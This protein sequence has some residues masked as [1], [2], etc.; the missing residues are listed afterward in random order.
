MTAAVSSLG[1]LGLG[2][3][4]LDAWAEFGTSVLG[5][6]RADGPADELRLRMDQR[7]QRFF[8]Y[9]SGEDDVVFLGLE[10][11][12]AA[13]LDAVCLRLEGIGVESKDAS[14][15]QREARGVLDMVRCEDPDGLNV[16][17][18]Y[19]QHS[20]KAFNSPRGLGGFV[21]GAQGLGHIVLS[22]SDREK[23]VEF[24][25]NGLGFLLSDIIT[26]P[27]GGKKPIDLTFLHCNPRHHTLALAPIRAPKRLNH[28]MLQVRD[29][30][31]VGS[32]LDVVQDAGVPLALGLGR[33]TND[34]MTSFYMRSP[35]GFDV[36]FGWGAREIDDS[37]WQVGYYSSGSLWGH[38]PPVKAG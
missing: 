29:F 8:L 10:V 22:V 15:E 12:D 6:E 32:T 9:P 30:N 2:V 26:I 31:D 18:Y 38:R 1:Y 11:K 13:T 7:S 25:T 14:P 21:T 4:D 16:E 20:G 36:E 17:I 27:F 33:H 37:T 24:Y 23:G 3:S 19:G 34:L 5:L 28:F 35:S